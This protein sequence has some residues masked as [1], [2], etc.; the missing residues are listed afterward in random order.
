MEHLEVKIDFLRKSLGRC[1]FVEKMHAAHR[2]GNF[3]QNW[4]GAGLFQ[5]FVM[6][7]EF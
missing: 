2:S 7:V 3:L 1:D 4:S 5:K 6:Q